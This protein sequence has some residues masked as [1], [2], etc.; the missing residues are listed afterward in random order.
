M[1]EEEGGRRGSW[2]KPALGVLLLLLAG[3]GFV[4]VRFASGQSPGGVV[5]V[6][7]VS[8][9]RLL[10]HGSVVGFASG[11]DTHAWL[12]IPYARPP[13]GGLRWRAPQ[14]A[15]AWADTRDALEFGRPC[16][17][18]GSDLA[19]VPSEDP[20]GFVGNEDC[21]Y[22][23]VW[24]PRS[25]PDAVPAGDARWPVLV[26]I[27]GGGNVSGWPGAK[28]YDAA[29][30][31]GRE[32]L[33]VVSLAYR[34][35]PLGWFSHPAIRA[36]AADALEASGNFGN[37]DQ[38][39]ALEWVQ[40]NVAEFGGDPTRVTVFGE[41]A[42][43]LDVYALL[44]SRAA[45]GLFQQAI[46]QS[47]STTAV[48]RAEAENPIDADP[49]GWATS[50]SEA[51]AA[52][53]ETVGVVPDRAAARDYAESLPAADLAD[54]LRARSGR[55]ILSV[56]RDPEAPLSLVVP[57]PIR[58]GSLL[59]AEDWL[60][61]FRSGAFHR[62]PIMAG[63]NR[64]EM[65][66]FLFQDVELV[67]RRF[68]LFYRIRDLPRYE[69]LARLQ[70]DA[71]AL[72]GVVEPATAINQAGEGAV[73]A[74]RFDWDDLPSVLGQDMGQLLGAAHG[75]ELPLLFGTWDVGDPIL[76]RLLYGD[77][78]P[79]RDRLSEQM[80]SYWAEFA[81]S[82]QPGRGGE[83]VL[84]Q[85]LP[86]DQGASPTGGAWLLLDAPEGG[87]LRMAQTPLS[88][89]RVLEAVDA[90]PN[91]GPFERCTLRSELLGRDVEEEAAAG[92]KGPAGRCVQEGSRAGGR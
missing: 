64:D 74:Y 24:A 72:R 67:R 34:L 3:A 68:G 6:A 62:V 30:L 28:L 14:A 59:P 37:L 16:L 49:P 84:P 56:Y 65:K 55:E 80:M 10:A 53:L 88:R 40:D 83:G 25:E 29:R 13:V 2:W 20:S 70:S 50:S 81:R 43:G 32:K 23:N 82:G 45:G 46:I 58:D 11:H 35:G 60:D 7:D 1:E 19:M 57:K 75:L 52:L 47:G 42:G 69:G 63:V 17:Q 54:L 31:A 85:W 71:W 73:Y 36:G 41:S 61:A 48:S 26:W 5:P 87:G 8:S 21:L 38:I 86:W 66:L 76:S 78:N 4:L 18:L 51:V 15:E 92:G 12:G 89:E 91:L 77:A 27:H 39:R 22:L 9:E 44:L 90:E 33:V 79:G